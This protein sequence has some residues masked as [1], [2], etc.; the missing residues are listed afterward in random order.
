MHPD[1][2]WLSACVQICAKA[3]TT[4]QAI[5]ITVAASS[6][7][8]PRQPGAKML[9]TANAQFDTIGGGNLE[10]QAIHTARAMLA[11]TTPPTLPILQ[12]IALGPSLG[13][14]CGGVVHLV[15]EPISKPSHYAH[16][17]Q[18]QQYWLTRQTSWRLVAL[19]QA[20]QIYLLNAQTQTM[21][22]APIQPSHPTCHLLQDAQ[23]QAYLADPCHPWRPELYLFGAGHVATHLI[24]ACTHLPCHITWIDQREELFPTHLPD[25]VRIDHHPQTCIR[26]APPG[27][28][29]LVM[30]HQH[31][32][33]QELVEAVLRRNDSLWLGLIGSASKR[34][35][36]EHRLLAK[37]IQA[38]A[39]AHLVCPVG[40]PGISN[41]LP[42]VIAAAICAQLL[43]TWQS[44]GQLELVAQ[45]STQPPHNAPANTPNNARKHP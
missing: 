28:S 13:Q 25:N 18:L 2:D 41:K 24:H 9:V 26:Q 14:C 37:G 43:Q 35:Q 10:Y 36:F 20:K 4:P 17:V 21:P 27:T 23:G 34:A 40:I 5:L 19:N 12:R 29:F 42:A 6:G 7:S 16:F 39:L 32:L 33:D 8:V 3:D 22:S 30:T 1:Q 45:T 31:T 44:A 15:F 38:A 11:A